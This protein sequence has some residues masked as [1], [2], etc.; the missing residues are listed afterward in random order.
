MDVVIFNLGI[1]GLYFVQFLP[2]ILYFD[3]DSHRPMNN[4]CIKSLIQGLQGWEKFMRRPCR[5]DL[6]LF[7][8]ILDLVESFWWQWCWWHR[9]VGDLMMVNVTNIDLT[10]HLTKN[11][12]SENQPSD[13]FDTPAKD[14]SNSISK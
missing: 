11:R 4:I 2:I 5:C 14:S 7:V 1:F 6:A 8:V 13:Q 10:N 3:T 12:D 9:Y